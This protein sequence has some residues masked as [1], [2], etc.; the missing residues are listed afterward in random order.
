M[1]KEIVDHGYSGATDSRPGLKE[2]MALARERKIDCVVCT[3]LDRLFRSLKHLLTVLD[4]FESLGILFV[5]TKDSVDLSTPAGRLMASVLGALG[6]FERDLIIE[7][8]HAGLEHAR[9]NGKRL[10]R[11]ERHDKVAMLV[12]RSEGLSYREIAART[13]APMG[14][15]ARAIAGARKSP[16]PNAVGARK[17]SGGYGAAE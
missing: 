5:A 6:A 11:P 12:L 17:K 16:S 13:G 14:C 1:V 9:R 10:G 15:V 2:L 8:T 4:E 3:K 7:R